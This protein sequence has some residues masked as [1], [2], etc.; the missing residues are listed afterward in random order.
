MPW[1]TPEERIAFSYVKSAKLDA[2][3]GDIE[4]ARAAFEQATRAAPSFSYALSE[5][6]KFEFQIGHRG[7]ALALAQRA[8][9]ASPN[10]YH[11]WL[12]LGIT[13]KKCRRYEKAIEALQ[14]AK[15]LNPNH[16]PIYNEL[17]SVFTFVGEYQKAHDQF[18]QALREEK[19]PNYRRQTITYAFMARN[20]SRWA[21]RFDSGVTPNISWRCS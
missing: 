14:K 4:G 9:E 13:L 12:G 2:V 5:Y 10:N 8:V 3:K 11:P 6:S 1:L 15:E 21:D 7:S 20:Y 17:G 19:Y 18:T 16:L